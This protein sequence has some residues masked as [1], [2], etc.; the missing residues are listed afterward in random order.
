[1]QLSPI[2]DVPPGLSLVNG[3]LAGTP[4]LAGN[5][6][7]IVGVVDSVGSF[8]TQTYVMTVDNAAGQA[9][10]LSLSPRPIQVYYEQG[11]PNPSAPVNVTTT[12]GLLPFTAM[13]VGIPGATLSAG[14][15]TTPTNLTVN[16]PAS[17]M[18]VGTYVGAVAV[19]A[20]D[21]ANLLDVVPVRLTVAPPPPCSYTVNPSATSMSAAGGMS[22]F[23]VLAGRGC[24]WTTSAPAGVQILSGLAGNGTGAVSYRVLSYAGTTS[25]TLTITVNGQP[26]VITQF[27]TSGCGFAITP[28]QITAPAGGAIT[29]VR[30]SASSTS[31]TC[32][33]TAGSTELTVT[34]TAGAATDTQVQVTIPP[35]TGA[36]SRTLTATIAGQTFSVLQPG[37][38]CSLSLSP[39]A[40]SAGAEGG[41]GSLTVNTPAGCA[42]ETT[43][44]PAWIAITSG[45]SGSGG[46][47]LLYS[48]APNPL[49]SPRVGTVVIGGQS[50]QVT[51]AALPCS[52]S[53]NTSALGT[54]Y[55]QDGATGVIGITVTGA[56]CAWAASSNAP[57][58]GLSQSSGLGSGSVGVTILANGTPTARTAQITIASQV[59]GISQDGTACT[60]SLQSPNGTVPPTGGSGSVGVVSPAACPW[61]ASSSSDPSWLTIQSATGTGTGEVGFVATA[62]QT[63][64]PRTATLSIAG[65]IYTVSQA[66][67]PCTYQLSGTGVP[68]AANGASNAFTFTTTGINCSPSAVSYAGWTSVDT[69]FNGTAGTV[70]FT[71]QPNPATVTRTATIRLGE[72]TFTITQ[73]GSACGFSLDTYSTLFGPPGGS[74]N[75]L[76]SPSAVGCVP[77]VGTDQPFVTLGTLTGPFANIFTQEY[78]VAPFSSLTRASRIAR[79]SFGGQ[80]LTV[81]QTSY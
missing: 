46:G 75:L 63:G 81:K 28:N 9:P 73:L 3:I 77:V 60:F 51:Q 36:P 58:L 40:A 13:V 65:G 19:K 68:V 71:V 15:G 20:N 62:N 2:S 22:S 32:G 59:I 76:A 18:A 37:T 39:Y 14:A 38:G 80:I 34:P 48:V 31:S 16:F 23:Q 50:Y 79:I 1:L 41:P 33:W 21:S 25:R 7:A 24:A 61:G 6:R 53:L 42:Y 74:R 47:A 67:A 27:G 72:Q 30:I 12:S 78:A 8:L 17:T 26:Y 29:T 45:G 43:S 56:N 4:T 57:W 70:T 44:T 49:T 66:M 5:F 69:V 54:P 64:A 11:S 35:N 55:G 10:A 52:V